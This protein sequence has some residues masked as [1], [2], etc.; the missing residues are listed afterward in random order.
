V[1]EVFTATMPYSAI[2]TVAYTPLALGLLTIAVFARQA[3][4]RRRNH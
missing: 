3:K 1:L 2:V 4:A